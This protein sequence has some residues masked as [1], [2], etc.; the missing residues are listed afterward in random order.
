MSNT[1]D[2]IRSRIQ[3]QF[4]QSPI[5]AY[6]MAKSQKLEAARNGEAFRPSPELENEIVKDWRQS[7]LYARHVL[8]GRFFKF[9]F[10]VQEAA[11]TA[12]LNEQAAVFHYAE[13]VLKDVWPEAEK[14]IES[15]ADFANR[16]AVHIMKAPWPEDH[17]ATRAISRDPNE[18]YDYSRSFPKEERTLAFSM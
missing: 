9:E 5:G 14:H 3:E 8:E 2:S 7:V 16:Y 18:N 11:P 12:N 10:A 6:Q 15:N 1:A 13:S 4:S 17:P